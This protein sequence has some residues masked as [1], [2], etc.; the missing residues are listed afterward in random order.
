[1]KTDER[2]RVAI[3]ELAPDILIVPES[4]NSPAFAREADM[5]HQWTGDPAIPFK[6][7]DVYAPTAQSLS[8]I[9]RP[10]LAHRFSLAVRAQLGSSELDV[11][12]VWTLPA[13]GGGYRSKYLNSLKGI[14]Q[15]SDKL[16]SG[17]NVVIAGDLNTSGSLDPQES[18]R[19]A[20]IGARALWTRLGLPPSD[21]RVPRRRVELDTL[22]PQQSGCR[23]PHRLRID[24]AKLVSS[25]GG[26]RSI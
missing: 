13:A 8:I 24:T 6:G 26:G 4:S 15:E 7:L 19:T 1:M 5:P 25:R 22:A 2:V 9:D 10:E 14:L 23:L 21:G 12:A 18:T 20:R 17:G 16:L 11:L 3:R